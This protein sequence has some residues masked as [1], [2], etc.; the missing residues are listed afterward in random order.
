MPTGTKEINVIKNAIVV[1]ISDG[2]IEFSPLLRTLN[3]A[4]SPSTSVGAPVDLG[5]ET[6]ADDLLKSFVNGFMNKAIGVVNQ[7]A[8]QVAATQTAKKDE[9]IKERNTARKLGK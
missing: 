4:G 7:N 8:K 9:A 2:K 5:L 1:Q 6:L 3:A